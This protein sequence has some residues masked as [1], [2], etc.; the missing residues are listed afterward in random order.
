MFRPLSQA[1]SQPAS[2][3]APRPA[4]NLASNLNPDRRFLLAHIGFDKPIVRAQGHYLY[5]ADGNRYLDC[6]AQYGALPFGHNPAFLWAALD[7]ARAAAE[8]SM[9]QPLIAPAAEALAGKLVELAPC[10][11]GYVTFSNSGAEAVESA[12]KLARAKTRRPLILATDQGFHGKTLGALSATGSA[13]YR[14]PFLLDTTRFAHIAYGD[15]AALERRLDGGDVAGFIVEPIQGEAGMITPPDGYLK[16]AGALCRRAKTLFILDEIQTGLGRTGHLFAAEREALDPDILLLAKALGGG[17]VSL[18][19]AICHARAW[20]ADFGLYHSS[21]FANNH[22]SCT[23]GLATLERL[24]QDG[25]E[26]IGHVRRVGHDLGEA[27]ARLVRAYPG[28]YRAASGRGLMQSLTL[29][30]WD[31][32][33]SYFLSHAS[34]TGMAAPLVCGYLLH[35]HGILIAPTF[36]HRNVLRLEPPLTIGRAHI[37]RLLAA[38]EETA[39]RLAAGEHG[40]LLRYLT[41]LPTPAPRAA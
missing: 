26:L 38:L 32:E 40:A 37:D 1:A 30:P 17:L 36:N 5:D 39:Q 21:T 22:L 11:A 6:L 33:Q 41:T 20:S 16:E 7:R 10:E 28:V 13:Q 8:P 3:P 15:L 2:Q 27:L 9:V 35:E 23:V 25:R 24:T 34:S 31:G 14:D 29:M 4:F 19:A 18:G 12:I